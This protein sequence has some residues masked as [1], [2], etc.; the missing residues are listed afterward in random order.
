M[1]EAGAAD[2]LAVQQ[3]GQRL[4]SVAARAGRSDDLGRPGL[5]ELVD[6]PQ[7]GRGGGFVTGAGQQ[8]GTGDDGPGQAAL[9]SGPDGGPPERGQDHV[10][11]EG[12]IEARDEFGEF[13]E[14]IALCVRAVHA[15]GL[16]VTVP[17]DD[18]SFFMAS[19]ADG[20]LVEAA[21]T[22]PVPTFAAAD[23]AA[24]ASALAAAGQCDVLGAGLVQGHQQFRD[25]VG[26][27]WLSG[28]QQ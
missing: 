12:G 3:L 16:A 14:K 4:H 21:R 2:S 6:E 1:G 20:G 17:A 18:A 28:P 27:R 11:V 25:A 7:G 10:V 9:A 19:R 8:L 15:A 26:R 22:A 13:L 24:C 23:V 5:D